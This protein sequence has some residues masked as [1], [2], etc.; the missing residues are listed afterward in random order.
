MKTVDFYLIPL[1]HK[2]P[3]SKYFPETRVLHPAIRVDDAIYD[4][5]TFNWGSHGTSVISDGLRKLPSREP[6]NSPL[7]DRYKVPPSV[8][9]T[10]T[11]QFA[12]HLAKSYLAGDVDW[13]RIAIEIAYRELYREMEYFFQKLHDKG[14][15]LP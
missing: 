1:T 11:S 15:C 4:L 14:G 7:W 9:L 12:R 10:S 13:V 2:G 8:F 6:A 3:N 5:I